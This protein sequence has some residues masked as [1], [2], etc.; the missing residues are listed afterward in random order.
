MIRPAIHEEDFYITERRHSLDNVLVPGE[1]VLGFADISIGIYGKGIAMALL[2]VIASFYGLGLAVF[3]GFIAVILVALE[4]TTR[5]YLLVAVTDQRIILGGGILAQE[6]VFL[7]YS[8][9]ETVETVRTPLGYMLGYATLLLTGTG[10]MR[11]AVPYVE[12]AIE[13]AEAI[14]SRMLAKDRAKERV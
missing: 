2:A 12:N 3:F 6:V 11:V 7:P 8:K 5:K 9:V 10:R 14:S 1:N 13:V 4:Y